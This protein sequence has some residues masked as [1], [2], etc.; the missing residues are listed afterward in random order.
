MTTMIAVFIKKNLLDMIIETHS[1]THRVQKQNKQHT[2]E[3]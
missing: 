2:V 1:V 3:I